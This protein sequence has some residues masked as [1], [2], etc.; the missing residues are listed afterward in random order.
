MTGFDR[1]AQAGK[2]REPEARYDLLVV[3]GGPAGAAAALTAAEGGA[4]VLLVD[5]N[6]VDPGLMGLD[7]PL[8]FG[9]RYTAEV[10]TPERLTAQVFAANPLLEAAMEAGVEIQLGVSCWGAWVPGWGLASLPGAIAGLADAERAWTVG[11]DRIVIATGARDVA[12]A[13]PGWNQPG[14]MGARGFLSLVETYNAFAGRRIVVLGSGALARRVV[15]AAQ[16]HGLEVVAA[17]E[18]ADRPLDEFGVRVLTNAVPLEARGGLD[19]VTGLKVSVGAESVNLACDTVVMA[20]SLTPTVELFDVLGAELAMQPSLGGHAPVS[21][22]AIA[23]SL[24]EVFVAGDSAGVPGGV[25]LTVDEAEASGRRAGRAVLASLGRGTY[26]PQPRIVAA[27]DALALQ[28]AW[29]RALNA[30]SP[31]ETI[32]CQCEEVTREALLAVRPPAYLG[33]PSPAQAKRDITSLLADGPANQDQIKRL[34]RACMGAC[35]ARRCR[36]QVALNLA[37]ASNEP[38][39]RT[40][41]AGYRAPVR[42]LPLKVI[43]AWDETTEMGRLWDVWMGVA[44][45]WTPYDDIGTE[46]EARSAGIFANEE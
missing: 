40:P 11:F 5:E 15:Q 24:P 25:P 13:F 33:P 16:A 6:P 39:E 36:E 31:A 8:W 27:G 35:Q 37:F 26:T 46:R 41:L 38:P 12:L 32:V 9:G 1:I 10:Q 19:G 44:G 4:S 3:G 2:H 14:V 42:P 23:T 28:A 7:V 22:D 18:I 17:V 29:L 43:A 45:Q 21:P 34:T 30:A 20:V